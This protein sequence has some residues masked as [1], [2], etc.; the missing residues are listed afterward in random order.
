VD[1]D[2]L[3]R[4]AD[5][6]LEALEDARHRHD[7]GLV[8]DLA[9]EPIYARYRHLAEADL[10][11]DLLADAAGRHG[12]RGRDARGL[13]RFAVDGAMGAATARHEEQVAER[14]AGAVL[15]LGAERIPFRAATARQANEADH[16]VRA[17]IEAA[18]M[19]VVDSDLTPVLADAWAV[20]HDLARDL[21]AASY[22]ALHEDL[23]QVDLD[24]LARS[25]G[26]LLD[27]TDDLYERAMDRGLRAAAGIGLAGAGRGD[28]P[29]LMRGQAHDEAFPAS[30]MLPALR[31][32][33]DGLGIDLDRQPNVV[34]DDAVRPGKSPRAYCAPVRVPGLVYLVIAPIGGVDDYRALMHEAGHAE[35]FA[36]IAAGLPV[37][38]RRMVEGALTETFAFL[39][40]GLVS[41]PSWLGHVLG[42]PADGDHLRDEATVRLF[43]H[44]RYA[45]KLRYELALH[46]GGPLDGMDRRYADELSR[47][48]RLEWPS[49]TWLHDV[50]EGL[51]VADYL[52]AWT[53]SSGLAAHLRERF[54]TRWYTRRQAGSLL[55][56]LWHEGGGIDGAVLAAELGLAD[57]DLMLLAEEAGRVLG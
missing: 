34:L 37:E 24:A 7:A 44:R 21:G 13:A 1:P 26:A 23:M 25:A 46:S 42:R 45:A 2:D 36:G 10:A 9:L 48:T 22:R 15:R 47:A 33:L 30:R 29:R 41:D 38:R 28:L 43:M 32:T 35:H 39:F 4:D 11:R 8:A 52:R 55:R 6:F 50:D 49:A 19:R 51:Y 14:E 20:R 5:A 53:L 3:R 12:D 57:G 31:R 18:R 40:D 54:G 27:A 16:A 56:E 17:E